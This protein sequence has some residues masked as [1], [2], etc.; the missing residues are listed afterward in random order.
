MK[1]S[2]HRSD[3]ILSQSIT[4]VWLCA[5]HIGRASFAISCPFR[6][7]HNLTTI[8]HGIPKCIEQKQQQQTMDFLSQKERKPKIPNCVDLSSHFVCHSRFHHK[9]LV[10]W[11]FLMCVCVLILIHRPGLIVIMLH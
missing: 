10:E 11:P 2:S 8:A 1:E 9:S 3:E 4:S 5:M 7:E 6:H